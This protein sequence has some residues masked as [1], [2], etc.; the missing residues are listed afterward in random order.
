M[1]CSVTCSQVPGIGTRACLGT[2][3]LPTTVCPLVPQDSCP[4]ARKMHLL[5]INSSK[6]FNPLQHQV[7][8]QNLIQLSWSYSVIGQ[9]LGVIHTG[10]EFFFICIPV[11]LQN[12]LSAPRIEWW[13]RQLQTFRFKKGESGKEEGVISLMFFPNYIRF[14]GLGRSLCDSAPLSGLWTP[15][16]ESSFLFNER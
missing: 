12:M 16:W 8:A 1:P 10:L 6:N 2:I 15:P 14:Q 13:D 11:E 7:K 9:I 5:S 4:S 3:I